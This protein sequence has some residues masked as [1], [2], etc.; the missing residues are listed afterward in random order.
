VSSLEFCLC[1]AEM[2]SWYQMNPT[3]T[4]AAQNSRLIVNVCARRWDGWICCQHGDARTTT[5]A[6]LATTIEPPKRIEIQCGVTSEGTE[7]PQVE[8]YW[9]HACS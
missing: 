1:S 6:D 4:I 7:E 5:P 3:A 9:P 2:G 8:G